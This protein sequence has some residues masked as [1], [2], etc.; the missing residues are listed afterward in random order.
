VSSIMDIGCY[1]WSGERHIHHPIGGVY[2]PADSVR[3]VC[4]TSGCW[5]DQYQFHMH[6]SFFYMKN[7][8]IMSCKDG[9]TFYGNK[10]KCID[11]MGDINETLA[12]ENP[13]CVNRK[14]ECTMITSTR[15]YCVKTCNLCNGGE[16][17][18]PVEQ[19]KGCRDGENGFHQPNTFFMEKNGDVMHCYNGLNF[20]GNKN[21]C[22]DMFGER[23]LANDANLSKLCESVKGECETST[24]TRAH[25]VKTCNLCNSDKII[26]EENHL[27]TS[28][29]SVD[30]QHSNCEQ[31]CKDGVG[32]GCREGFRLKDDKIKCE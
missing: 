23:N 29:N 18:L 19:E 17:I 31:F 27:N 1:H 24:G 10:N 8:D 11:M 7:G 13:M 12:M 22:Q 2:E 28:N 25:C 30:C 5:D 9:I 15:A 20:Y 32:C 21:N 4:Q 26:L 6:K 3:L 16:I 14:I